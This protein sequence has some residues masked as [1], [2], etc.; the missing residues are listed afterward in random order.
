M[1][2]LEKFIL[3]SIDDELNY[4]SM[5]SPGHVEV[6][7]DGMIIKQNN[8]NAIRS[9]FDSHYPF[10][11]LSD[12]GLREITFSDVTL[13]CGNNGS[14]KSTLLNI[15]AQKLELKRNAPYNRTSFFDDYVLMCSEK[16]I[17]GHEEGFVLDRDGKIITSDDVF[18]YNLSV[19]DKNNSIDEQRERLFSQKSTI[20]V[21][22]VI[23]FTDKNSIEKYK[24]AY[25]LSS[26]SYSRASRQFVGNNL[27]EKSNGEVGFEYFIENITNGGLYLL[28]EPENSLSSELQMELKN[29][30]EAMSR[31]YNCQ[32]I[33]ATHSPFLLSIDGATIYDMDK[34]HIQSTKW[35]DI[36]DVRLFLDFFEREKAKREH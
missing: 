14:G 8:P 35:E 34:Y 17:V 11:T 28:D 1:I 22:R 30:I 33:I 32:F 26:S 29:Y 5:I 7:R 21:P 27:R 9:C 12:K 10:V 31:C 6:K 36:S 3:P 2:Y 20:K 4:F 19:R 16:M 25:R 24:Q 23:D 18:D 13:L 15:I